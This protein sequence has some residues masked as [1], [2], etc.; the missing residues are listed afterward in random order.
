MDTG[1]TIDRYFQSLQRN[2]A[3]DGFLAEDMAFA[4]FVD[5]IKTVAGRDA[6]LDATQRFFSMVTSVEVKRLIVE[7]DHACALTHYRLQPPGGV[8]FD[9]QVAEVFMVRGGKIASLEIYFDSASFQKP[10]V[11][12]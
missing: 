8:P 6:Y 10:P 3:W 5:P 4:S 12:A 2:Q 7:G 9:S 11:A 1:E